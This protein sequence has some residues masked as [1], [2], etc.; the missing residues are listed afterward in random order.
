[1]LTAPALVV[2]CGIAALTLVASWG[3]RSEVDNQE[4]HALEQ[5]SSEFILTLSGGLS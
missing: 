1:M 2:L 5:R 3:V 4:Q